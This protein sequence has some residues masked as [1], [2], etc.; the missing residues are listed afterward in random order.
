MKKLGFLLTA[1]LT[2]AFLAVSVMA[3]G[4]KSGH[5]DDEDDDEETENVKS[6]R[7]KD[8]DGERHD[9]AHGN[10]VDS[11]CEDINSLTAQIASCTSVEE[12]QE[13]ED[14][15]NSLEHYRYDDTELT[16]S[17]KQALTQSLALFAGTVMQQAIDLSGE[18]VSEEEQYQAGYALGEQIRQVVAGSTTLAD[19]CNGLD[20]LGN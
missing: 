4:P 17:D 9:V 12:L 15:G 14:L 6:R 8:K 13:L 20:N 2:V 19:V 18:Y 16:T 1:A 10:S 5:H 7:D 11:F 3:C